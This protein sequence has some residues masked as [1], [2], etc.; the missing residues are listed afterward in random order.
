MVKKTLY[1]ITI[2]GL[3]ELK[4][5]LKER[6]EV[7]KKRLQDQLD[8]ELGDGDISENSNYYK[9]QDEIASNDKRIDELEHIIHNS[10]IIRSNGSNIKIEQG[11]TVKLSK[12]GKEITY[13]VVGETESDPAKNKI[14]IESP[15]GSAL[16][17]KKKGDHVVMETPLGQQKYDIIDIS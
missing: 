9:V 2:E 12:E 17:G 1:K 13:A 7:I 16:R 10:E 8:E 14:S 3:E 4:K 6:S 5:E 15:L 11:S